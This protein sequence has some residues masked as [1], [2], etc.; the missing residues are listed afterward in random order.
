M[1][2]HFL[3]RAFGLLLA[4]MFIS[5]ASLALTQSLLAEAESVI[6]HCEGQYAEVGKERKR[7]VESIEQHKRAFFNRFNKKKEVLYKK[8]MLYLATFDE[9][10]EKLTQLVGDKVKIKNARS[11]E[12][13]ARSLEAYSSNCIRFSQGLRGFIDWS[14]GKGPF[15][16]DQIYNDWVRHGEPMTK[17]SN[18]K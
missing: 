8:R 5:Q 11:T 7:L 10:Y 1:K 9:Q 4:N 17:R 18:K 3:L 13:L 16:F 2:S 12:E 15:G 14:F 6:R